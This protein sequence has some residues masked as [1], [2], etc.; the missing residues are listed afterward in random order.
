VGVPGGFHSACDA[1][2]PTQPSLHGWGAHPYNHTRLLSHAS[3]P[4][5][6]QVAEKLLQLQLLQQQNQ[7]LRWRAHVLENMVSDVDKQLESM[8][9]ADT[10]S[11]DQ[12]LTLL[13]L[14]RSSQ[15]LAKPLMEL[16]ERGKA[17]DVSK[18]TLQECVQ[19]WRAYVAECRRLLA[20][21]DAAVAAPGAAAAAQQANCQQLQE[22]PGPPAAAEE[23][24]KEELPVAQQPGNSSRQQPAAAGGPASQEPPHQQQQQQQQDATASGCSKPKRAAAAA[25]VKRIFQFTQRQPLDAAPAGDQVEPGASRKGKVA[26]GP[27]GTG[28]GPDLATATAVMAAAAEEP[29]S[30]FQA[31]GVV[32]NRVV[33]GGP[34]SEGVPLD[35]LSAVEEQVL[36]NI[37]WLLALAT[38]NN[39]VRFQFF[40]CDFEGGGRLPPPDSDPMWDGV[41]AAVQLT[42]LQVH[43]CA[44]CLQMAGQLRDRVLRERSQLQQVLDQAP[45]VISTTQGH[46]SSSSGSGGASRGATPASGGSGGTGVITGVS[47]TKELDRMDGQM[48]AVQAMQKN[49]KQEELIKHMPGFYCSNN[50]SLLQQARYAV[51]C[52][53]WCASPWALFEAARRHLEASA[54]V[55]ATSAQQKLPRQASSDRRHAV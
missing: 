18:V 21:V 50:L 47:V 52:W 53:P 37:A 38:S 43:E 35:L 45:A 17:L 22:L 3:L 39:L 33:Y 27:V 20:L 14:G 2:N 51:A 30:T 16:L 26:P 5:V 4:S 48:A 19:R 9:A 44:L 42:P 40:A 10:T 1:C 49:F 23:K 46:G 7:Q 6:P 11:S 34:G 31:R 13:L 32:N 24:G 25:A 55:T 15:Q 29:P 54:K 41:L 8:A 12:W 28:A 36:D